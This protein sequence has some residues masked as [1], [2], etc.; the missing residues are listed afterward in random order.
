MR[1]TFSK[2][3]DEVGY[4][5]EEAEARKSKIDEAH[6]VGTPNTKWAESKIEADPRGGYLIVIETL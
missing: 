1:D 6:G 3:W 2:N 4:T 5:K